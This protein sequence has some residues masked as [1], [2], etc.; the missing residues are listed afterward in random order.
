V[1]GVEVQDGRCKGPTWDL[2]VTDSGSVLSLRASGCRWS[3]L[4]LLRVHAAK[5]CETQ[6]PCNRTD[7]PLSRRF[8]TKP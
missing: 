5:R 2:K 7:T 6:L 8:P 4:L 1:G 3:G